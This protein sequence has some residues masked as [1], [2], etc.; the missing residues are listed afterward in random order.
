M[1]APSSRRRGKTSGF[2][3]VVAVVLTIITASSSRHGLAV[4]ALSSAPAS[5]KPIRRIA[6][7][8][9]GISGL[10][11]AHALTNSV[12]HAQPAAWDCVHVFDARPALDATA[13]AGIQLNGG[14]VALGRIHPE[15]RQ[16]VWEAGRPMTGVQSRGTPWVVEGYASTE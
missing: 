2:L 7:I 6:V 15:L 10:S 16:T 11:V 9:A 3:H 5:A 8:G 4:D 13:G 12:Q 1:V 14:L